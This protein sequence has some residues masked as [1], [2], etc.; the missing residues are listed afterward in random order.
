MVHGD[1]SIDLECSMAKLTI[2]IFLF[3]PIEIAAASTLS[4]WLW[5]LEE[6]LELS[7]TPMILCDIH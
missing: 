7:G 4:L 1:E 3:P 2:A 5:Q 6:G